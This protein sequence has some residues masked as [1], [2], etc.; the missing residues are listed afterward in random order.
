[1]LLA[2]DP[3]DTTGVAEFTSDGKLMAMLQMNMDEL[4]NY[5]NKFNKTV[6]TVV[7]EDFVLFAKRAQKQAGSRMKASQA[8]G[9][10][11]GFAARHEAKLVIQ[12]ANIKPIALKQTGIR[13]PSQHSKTHQYDAYLHGAY[14]LIGKGIMKTKLQLEMEAQNE[15]G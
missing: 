5:L 8:I 1:M 9:L 10:I 11:R 4:I 2:F 12:Q 14:Y 6:D 13:L 3:G 7:V 15:K